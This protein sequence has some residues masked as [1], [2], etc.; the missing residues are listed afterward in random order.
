MANQ[1]RLLRAALAYAE[2]LGVPVF[3]AYGI[4]DGRCECGNAVC[5]SPGKHPRTEKGFKDASADVETIGEWWKRWPNSN[6]GMPTGL[7][8][9]LLV[10]DVDLPRGEQNLLALMGSRG[11]IPLTALQT[12]GSGGE[13]YFFC[14][15]TDAPI[16]N[17][18]GSHGGIADN[19]DIRG[20]GGY[21]I[22]PPSM[23]VSGR[24]YKW[25]DSARIDQVGANDAPEWLLTLIRKT[26][27]APDQNGNGHHP[28]N[29]V[30]E[31]GRNDFLYRLARSLRSK[32]HRQEATILMV[33]AANQVECS[34]PLSGSE[35]QGIVANAYKQINRADFVP[36]KE[37]DDKATILS[38]SDS[39]A[40]AKAW[41]TKYADK[42]AGR[43]VVRW[44]ESFWAWNGAHFASRTEEDQ[45]AYLWRFLSD[46]ALMTNKDGDPVHPSART[47]SDV[48]DALRA[49]INLSVD[50]VQPPCW[51]GERYAD[52][53]QVIA[54]QNGLLELKSGELLPATPQFF[55]LSSIQC[56]Y[57]PEAYPMEWE[58]FLQSI[59]PEEPAQIETLQ[60]IFGYLLTLNTEQ[61]KMFMIIGPSRS[62][63]GTIGRVIQELLGADTV[64]RPV[65]SDFGYHFGLEKLIGKPL[66]IISDARLDS[67]VSGATLVERLLSISGEDGIDVARKFRG[68]WRGRL[69]TRFVLLTNELPRI[70]DASTALPGR[71]IVLA[72]RRSFLGQEDHMIFE[73]VKKELPGVLN[74]AVDGWRRL[75]DRGFFKQPDGVQEIIDEFHRLASPLRAFVEE[76]CIAD[77]DSDME[78]SDL[79]R[80]YK[81]WCE[82]QGNKPQSVQMF[83]RDLRAAC[84]ELRFYRPHGKPRRVIGLRQMMYGIEQ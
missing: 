29:G 44:D 26:S 13:Q 5:K 21:V 64:A 16:Y 72:T 69:A 6:I 33:G 71:F 47:V 46:E 65:L 61:Q 30:P 22:L 84:P 27:S 1:S 28:L 66:A 75:Y 18:A 3:P 4:T 14:Y 31:G 8:S 53:R 15:P 82:S 76:S 25:N 80:H 11:T 50:Q 63:K 2:R 9:S 57:K 41:A 24:P 40:S 7:A 73:R 83:G 42:E 19:L 70:W 59:W 38:S 79:H 48:I 51:L 81:T 74:W 68:D 37:P 56:Q 35:V 52:P 23:H 39:M 55:T 34:P 10:L 77:A 60:E 67:S 43:V 12:T 32:R 20:E 54:T 45:R 49:H 36:P 58:G 17:S 78:L 62:G